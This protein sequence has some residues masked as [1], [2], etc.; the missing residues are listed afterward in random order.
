MGALWIF[1]CAAL[2]ALTP[3]LIYPF[4]PGFP[5]DRPLGLPGARAATL[6][7]GDGT[8]LTVW[9]S[10]PAPGAPV[11]L[12]FMGNAGVLPSHAPLLAALSR[13]GLG[14]AALNYRGASG[15]PGAPS[16]TALTADA[17]AL[18]DGL[19]PLF[20]ASLPASRRVIWGTSLGAAL[21]VQLA[22]RR[23]ALALVLE[24]PFNRLCEAAQFHYPLFP[25]CLVLPWERWDSAALIG[26]IDM[27]LL[28]LQG[29]ADTIIPPAHGRRLLAAA[30]G[31]KRLIA[32]PG[33]GHND[34][35]AAAAA[36]DA[37]A[38]IAGL[39]AR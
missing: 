27:P 25:A 9:L 24:S 32:Y 3:A 23:P 17:L 35:P 39:A 28:M 10:D 8:P 18:Y 6:M 1:A 33:A 20:G 34:L 38:F 16:Q 29:S 37:A 26:G 31:P 15:A 5:V 21:A 2:V 30:P 14:I 11:V 7:A 4:Q 12:Y 36:R 19:D 13:H 22:A